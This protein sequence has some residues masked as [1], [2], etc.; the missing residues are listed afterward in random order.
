MYK[1]PF[2]VIWISFI[3]GIFLEYKLNIKE[4]NYYYL[5]IIAI[6]IIA[7]LMVSKKKISL[8]VVVLSII[9]GGFLFKADYSLDYSNKKE[10]VALV[11]TVRKEEKEYSSYILKKDNKNYLIINIYGNKK[12][13]VGDIVNIK[14][15]LEN[16]PTN[17]NKK[18]FNS[19][20]YYKSQYIHKKIN[21]QNRNIQI[22]K[23][24]ENI[25]NKE[26]E[27]KKY[28]EKNI[29]TSIRSKDKVILIAMITGDKSY[30]EKENL[31]KIRGI[32]IAHILAISGFH[33]G[34]LYGGVYFFLFK[35]MR[36]NKRIS[37]ILSITGIWLYIGVIGFPVS[38]IR[39]GIFISLFILSKL[40]EMRFDPL[41][42]TGFIGLIIL[43][44]KP[45]YILDL[46]YQLSFL[47]TV[48]I[49]LGLERNISI[50]KS[51][52]LGMLPVNLYYFNSVSLFSIIGNLIAVPIISIAF[53]LTIIG[54]FISELLGSFANIIYF[55]SEFFL[56]IFSEIV[57]ILN[58]FNLEIKSNT[59]VTLL[60]GL[61]IIILIYLKI[62]NI[63][64]FPKKILHV[65]LI[66]IFIA[67]IVNFRGEENITKINFLD[68]GQGDSSVI[69]INGQ[70]YIIDT[71][72]NMF[73]NR[74]IGKE[75]VL[76]YLEKNKSTNIKKIFISHFHED[77]G[78]GYTQIAKEI[79]LEELVIGYKN[80]KNKLYRDTVEISKRENIEINI[81][82]KN[83][84][85]VVDKNNTFYIFPPKGKFKSD[86][87]ENNR[88][89]TILLETFG[90]KILFTGDVE[91]EVERGLIRENKI[92]NID[93]VKIPH[94]G[95]KTSSSKAFLDYIKPK[96]GVIQVGKNS[97]GHPNSDII[98]R[99]KERNTKIFRTD[100]E[101]EIEFSIGKNF[102]D[103]EK[104]N[105]NKK[106]SYQETE[107]IMMNIG[108]SIIVFV[109]T[110]NYIRKEYEFENRLQR[111]I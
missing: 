89:M 91:K 87:N 63:R 94:H 77:H 43:I 17:T 1:R 33:I 74:E 103:M 75:I 30:I 84:K 108:C 4:K 61:Y 109:L 59:D 53:T 21:L 5:G 80:S 60:I 12:L 98:E 50:Y 100:I 39:A 110:I 79:N 107:D 31:E 42:T 65:I 11:E 99:Y 49:L 70:T 105:S 28:I 67:N 64:C 2:F 62:I 48:F 106:T 14:G 3:I 83:S 95:S 92:E 85:I 13:R 71:G 35:I 32:G 111:Y 41:N 46:G 27:F 97:F 34:L 19:K 78:E 16:I 72:G 22:L 55:I 24:N 6:L 10:N 104:H 36:L 44:Y 25:Y 93:I 73:G 54:L 57:E 7:I 68:V 76:P 8:V 37:Q 101:G 9:I 23:R 90:K 81:V 51:I 66:Y 88:T 40:L 15:E 96:I 20:D 26:Y 102:L 82:E 38:A 47:G 86:K 56:K 69:D 18:L 52:F 58:Y 45:L 29:N